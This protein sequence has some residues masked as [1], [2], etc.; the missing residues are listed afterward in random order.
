MK[1]IFT[2]ILGA[3]VLLLSACDKTY[4]VSEFYKDKGL[5]ETY[6]KKC[7]NGEINAESTNCHNAGRARLGFRD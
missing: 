7:S 3:S 5:Q 4:T 2:V 6:I 1:N